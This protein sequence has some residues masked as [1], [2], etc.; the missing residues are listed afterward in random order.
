MSGSRQSETYE[1]QD[2]L[3]NKMKANDRHQKMQI[4]RGVKGIKSYESGGGIFTKANEN[5]LVEV[6]EADEA[7][8]AAARTF[9]NEEF[10]LKEEPL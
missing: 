9:S 4:D 1:S 5:S 3:A 7:Y 8:G 10:S 2:R 6:N